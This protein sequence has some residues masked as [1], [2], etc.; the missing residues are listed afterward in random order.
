MYVSIIIYIYIYN[1][2]LYSLFSGAEN[3]VWNILKPPSKSAL[4]KPPKNTAGGLYRL[5][6][7]HWKLNTSMP[8]LNPHPLVR[9]KIPQK[10]RL[11]IFS[12]ISWPA[13]DSKGDLSVNHL[14]NLPVY[15]HFI[16][17]PNSYPQFIWMNVHI[18]SISLIK[19]PS[20]NGA[21]QIKAPLPVRADDV[22]GS[23]V[24]MNVM[25]S[26]GIMKV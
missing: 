1:Y 25:L 15:Y 12:W 8:W 4:F 20:T 26:D 16:F 17:Y 22:P 14:V 19:P 10:R 5:P 11:R 13:M 7:V 24:A 21:F 2:I 6:P 23:E 18:P 9:W 3:I